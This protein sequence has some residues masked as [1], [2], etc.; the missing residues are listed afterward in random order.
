MYKYI[1]R[2]RGE[3]YCP[4]E[5]ESVPF[6][7]YESR[8]V[9]GT[10][11][12]LFPISFEFVYMCVWLPFVLSR[13]RIMKIE[14]DFD[15]IS[16]TSE[17]ICAASAE[18]RA[19]IRTV[20]FEQTLLNSASAFALNTVKLLVW[21]CYN[22][23]NQMWRITRFILLCSR[24]VCNFPWTVSI[25]S[26]S[27][28]VLRLFAIWNWQSWRPDLLEFIV[29]KYQRKHRR[30]DLRIRMQPWRSL[31]RTY[32]SWEVGSCVDLCMKIILDFS[33]ARSGSFGRRSYDRLHFGRGNS[34]KLYVRSFFAI[35][36]SYLVHQRQRGKL[37]S[38]MWNYLYENWKLFAKTGMDVCY[39]KIQ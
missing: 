11:V 37:K 3:K 32:R 4:S 22:A 13:F 29:A 12:N 16:D 34:C 10:S 7:K 31:V 26:R 23:I 24:L 33:Y 27:R 39:V 28:N 6:I 2:R 30:F 19:L 18:R 1:F 35:E 9:R 25:C 8:F 17:Y 15:R 5:F 21:S 14:I 20:I 38:E 36:W